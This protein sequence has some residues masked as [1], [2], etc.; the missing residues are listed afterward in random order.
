ML[1]GEAT[2]PLWFEPSHDYVG[3]VV[4]EPINEPV[5]LIRAGFSAVGLF[6]GR[7]SKISHEQNVKEFQFYIRMPKFRVL[8]SIIKK[9]Y[10]KVADPLKSYN[11]MFLTSRRNFWMTK[12]IDIRISIVTEEFTRANKAHIRLSSQW[13]GYTLSNDPTRTT[14]VSETLQVANFATYVI[15]PELITK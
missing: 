1:R 14:I 8:S 2:L 15:I 10:P 6:L 9:K 12:H 7:K 13:S 11:T 4:M 5:G 3:P